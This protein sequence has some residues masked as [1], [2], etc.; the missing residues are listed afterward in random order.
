MIPNWGLQFA[1]SCIE[2][3]EN[4]EVN[5]KTKERRKLTKAKLEFPRLLFKEHLEKN[6]K[7]KQSKNLNDV[8]DDDE[9]WKSF[10]IETKGLSSQRV[11]NLVVALD[12]ARH[13]M[14]ER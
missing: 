2:W 8:K 13:Y 14:C 12:K 7:A 3:I 11:T 5:A 6:L 1:G 10:L 9:E 4:E